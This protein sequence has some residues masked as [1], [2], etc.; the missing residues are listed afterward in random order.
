MGAQNIR[1]A[2]LVND[3]EE[4]RL[5]VR[6]FFQR[7]QVWTNTDKEFFID[8][9]LNS[10]PFPEIFV[11]TGALDRKQIKL[12]QWL[13][14]GQQ[15]VTTL[16]AYIRGSQYLLYRTIK[17][18][19]QLTPE[20][21]D[22]FLNYEVAVRDLGAVDKNTIKEI[23]RRINSTDY[24]LKLM[25]VLNAMY[26][27]KYKQ[28]CEA[29]SRQPFFDQHKV[30]PEAY[31]K[32]MYDLTFCVILVTTVLAGYYRRDEK[33]AEY[34]ERYNDDFPDEDRIQ[35]EL[36]QVFDFVERC[37]FAEHSRAWKQTDLF[38]LLV[39]LHSALIVEK[40]SLN[41]ESVGQTLRVFYNQVDQLYKGR[42][43]P[44]EGEVPSGQE[45]VFRY[46]KAATKATNDKYARVERAEVVSELIRLT[47]EDMTEVHR[48]EH[49]ARLTSAHAKR[50]GSARD[51][52]QEPHNK[53]GTTK[54]RKP[55][56]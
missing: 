29:L 32:R 1:I 38:T 37:G 33:N 48:K 10:Y 43:L 50:P 47:T 39:E 55:R 41:T 7:R 5:E 56:D 44:D 15:R 4:G 40:M 24:A 42:K 12:K 46:L 35:A 11:A 36:D 6:P 14:D 31:R 16:I 17:P 21:Q 52:K 27:G 13:V 54:T 23:F 49:V 2:K 20:A 3:V 26:S 25:E 8:T 18:F 51:P 22:A 9:I 34:L 19:D 45:Q 30:F 53:P 28:Y